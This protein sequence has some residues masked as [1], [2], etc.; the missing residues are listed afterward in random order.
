[1]KLKIRD[2]RDDRQ[3]RAVVALDQDRFYQLLEKFT[4]AYISIYGKPLRERLLE[5][6]IEYCITNEEELL[7]FTLFSI[8][9]GLTYDVLGFIWGMNGSNAKTN[10]TKGLAVLNTALE[11]S[12]VLPK[13]NFM[14]VQE[15]HEYF[16]HEES[17]IID[18]TE[19]TIQRPQDKDKQREFYSGKKK[20][21]TV[22]TMVIATK[23]RL[24]KYV[25][26]C[27]PGRHHDYAILK[28]EFSK[29]KDWFKRH[30]THVDLG[31]VG[32]GKDY[33]C[34][35][36][37]IP[38]KKPRN[39]ELTESQKE[40]NRSFGSQRIAVEN[41]LAGIKRYRILSDRLRIHNLDLYHFIFSICVGLWN[42]YLAN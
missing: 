15:F 30:K 21:H 7:F 14:N 12:G 37:S 38:H 10:Q 25:S 13:S 8:K 36:I 19:Q 22:K 35:D 20:K 4:A 41:S 40:E 29:G 18:T 33:P 32:I 9:S 28:Q 27:Y 16:A 31:Y 23:Q 24:I 1:M 6:N 17:L 34:N 5:T 3:W 11:I 2:L 39:G 42:F 26:H